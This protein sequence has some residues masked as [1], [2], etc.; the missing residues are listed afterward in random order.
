MCISGAPG[1]LTCY[2]CSS[3]DP[4][5]ECVMNA[6]LSTVTACAPA[7]IYCRVYRQDSQGRFVSLERGCAAYCRA[8]CGVWGD[9]VDD[10]KCF[11]CCQGELCNTDNS[12]NI[13]RIASVLLLLGLYWFYSLLE[14]FSI[15][16]M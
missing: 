2:T 9:D 7:E 3:S 12:A 1:N 10:D 13:A 11:S 14:Q 5:G 4:N 6:T 16:L 8:G 15:Q